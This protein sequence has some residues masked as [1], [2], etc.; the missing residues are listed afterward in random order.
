M[1]TTAR[2]KKAVK[3]AGLKKAAVKKASS[4]RPTAGQKKATAKK[5]AHAVKKPARTT[6]GAHTWTGKKASVKRN[7]APGRRSFPQLEV[8]PDVMEFIGAID[9]FK[10]AHSR[11]FPSWSEVLHVLRQLGYRKQ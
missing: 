10:K 3:R 11:P 8:D 2:K 7:K 9:R 6:S 4:R 5:K 1:G